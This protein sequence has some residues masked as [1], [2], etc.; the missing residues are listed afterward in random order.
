MATEYLA[1]K[2][3][4]K[5]VLEKKGKRFDD[6]VTYHDPCHAKKMQGIHKE[7]RELISKNYVLKE[8]SD[9]N[10]CCGFGGVTMQSEKY[11]FAVAAGLP[12]AAMIKETKAK[13]VSAECSACRMQITN[14]LH[15]SDVDVVFK[16]PIELIAEA[17]R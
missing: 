2:T 14:S 12:K 9:P 4:L 11:H 10:R 7:P 3:N 15:Q 16:N 13:I 6:L 5:E 8:M 1:K 17:I